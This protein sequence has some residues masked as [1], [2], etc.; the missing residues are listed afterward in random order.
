MDWKKSFDTPPRQ[1]AVYPMA[2]G[3][4]SH[5]KDYIDQDVQNG[6]GGIVANLNYTPDFPDNKAEWEAMAEGCRAYA[7]KGLRVWIYDEKGYPSGTAGGAVLE[8]H[9]EFEAV[10]LVCFCYWKVLGKCSFYRSDTPSGQLYKAFLVRQDKEAEAIDITDTANENGTLRFSV[11][12]GDYRLLVLVRRRLFDSTHAAH[13][14]SEPRRYID[15]FNPEATKAFIDCTYEK[16]AEHIGD[17]FGEAMPAFFTDEPSLIGWN[18]PPASYPLLSWSDCFPAE[19]EKRYGYGIE[20]AL[21]AVIT[22]NGPDCVKRRCDFWNLTAELLSQNFFRVLQEWCAAHHTNLSGHLLNEESLLAQLYCYGSFYRCLKQFGQPG[23]DLLNSDPHDLMQHETIPIA[24]LAGSVADIFDRTETMS[25]SSE[26]IQ[27]MRSQSLP[28]D[29]LK[30]TANWHFALGVNNITSYYNMSVFS[31]EELTSFNRYF[32]RTGLAVR[33]GIRQNRV[34]MLCPDNAMFALFRPTEQARNGGQCEE[35][36]TVNRCFS[37]ASWELLNRQIDFAYLDEEELQKAAPEN[38]RLK[39]RSQQFDT[40]LLP[41]AFVLEAKTLELICRFIDAGGQV[42]ALDRMPE[43]TR[44]TGLACPLHEKLEKAKTDGR[45]IFGFSD[46]FEEF[47]DRL[48]RSIRLIPDATVTE[49]VETVGDEKVSRNILSHLRKSETETVLYLCNMG[50]SDYRGVIEL[51]S[52]TSAK[53]GDPETGEWTELPLCDADG[54]KT[55]AIAVKG[56][57]GIILVLQ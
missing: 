46:R 37:K 8:K 6:W 7:E 9:P 52:C 49:G 34:A 24:R 14:Y 19:F 38:G 2:H 5:Y 11:P 40:L 48:P 42:I 31:T 23:I 10:G 20:K 18:I 53:L 28:M 22:G 55:A 50:E 57:R 1:Y 16:Y 12:E 56:Y 36:A 25:E 17:L 26:L 30:A 47:T 32:A 43:L 4:V 54:Q 35:L 39:L 3:R 44:E 45:L 33:Q 21:V 51:P 13:S 27:N 41:A 29:W 15:L